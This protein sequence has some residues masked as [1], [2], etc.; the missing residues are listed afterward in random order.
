MRK[1]NLPGALFFHSMR[2]EFFY[3]FPGN[4]LLLLLR[5]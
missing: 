4:F 1:I 3:L 2:D 5:C